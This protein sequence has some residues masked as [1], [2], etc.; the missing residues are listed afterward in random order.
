LKRVK[1]PNKRTSFQ[2]TKAY[3]SLDENGH[4]TKNNK[5]NVRENKK[6]KQHSSVAPAW[7]LEGKKTK[8]R[9]FKPCMG[10]IGGGARRTKRV[11]VGGTGITDR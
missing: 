7:C 9:K 11:A 6:W 10:R 4:N 3:W 5:G 1:G 2:G 8:Q